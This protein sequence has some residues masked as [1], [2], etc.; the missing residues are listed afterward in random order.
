[1]KTDKPFARKL[2]RGEEESDKERERGKWKREEGA[3]LSH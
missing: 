1:M 3:V 2:G